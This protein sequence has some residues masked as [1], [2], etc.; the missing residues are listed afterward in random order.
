MSV[1][2]EEISPCRRK[3]TVDV[4][5]ETIDK[6]YNEA[7]AMYVKNASIPGFRPGK[8]PKAM[9]KAK[10]N[11]D[12]LQ[13]LRD[14]L[15]PQTYRD[16][17]TEHKLDVVQI[18][19]M[20]DDVKIG[21]GEPM[22]YSIT[23]D[24]RPEISLPE[25]K[26]IALTK[27]AIDLADADVDGRIEELRSQHARF[28]DLSDRG[29]ARGDMAQVDLLGTLDGVA[30]EEAVPEARGL[31]QMKDFWMQASGEAFL[32]ELG[33]GLAGMAIG[34]TRSI[35]VSFNETFAL[36]ALR[37]KTVSYQAT[38]KALR[39]K[40]LPEIDEAFCTQLGVESVEKLREE[41]RNV[42]S[43]E[44]DREQQDH[45]RRDIEKFLMDTCT[46]EMPE[47]MV[48][49]AS[50]RQVRRIA[51]EMSRGGLKEEQILAQKD[52]I[53]RSANDIARNSV[54]LRLILQTIA[55]KE[56][57]KVSD[58]EL[59]REIRMMS[60]TYGM[61]PG[62]LEKRMKD[63]PELRS[64]MAVDVQIRKTLQYLLDNATIS[65]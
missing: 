45:L 15:L 62:E 49:E 20:S 27:K 13:R 40:I 3:L 12:I 36:D 44:K 6:E 35:D 57:I 64:D 34:E 54:K 55:Q 25:Y 47:S 8:A 59:Q 65:A 26:G 7:L 11:K 9:V 14:H 50:S 43:S 24:V 51:D 16:A 63:S 4:P 22:T 56:N 60:Y 38:L 5:A 61:K 29:V 48:A 46:F 53:L 19:D 31:G 1:Q 58:A 39:G 21:L 30:L 37:G 32:P 42:I 41:I 28:E 10:F 2:I 33:E 52:E 17:V 23:V 18:I